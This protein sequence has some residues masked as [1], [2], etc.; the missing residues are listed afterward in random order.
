MTSTIVAR[1]TGKAAK[2]LTAAEELILKQGFKGVTMAAVAQRAHVGKGTAYL[3]WRTKEDLFLELLVDS[4]A[5]V[6]ADL[7][8]RVRATP[9]LAMA[10]RLCPAIAD[11]WLA[12][13]LVRALQV[14]DNDVLGA[15][16]DDPRSHAIVV[17]NGIP[18][19]IGTLLPLWRD[20]DLV[21]ADWSLDDV[22]AALEFLFVG[23]FVTR[24]RGAVGGSHGDHIDVLRR[25]VAAV[26]LTRESAVPDD[27]LTEA[28]CEVLE[29][30]AQRLRELVV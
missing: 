19:L 4:L 8:D 29:N 18:A 22:T 16:L 30:H 11:A 13:P 10:D 28:V 12:R 14:T 26:L 9:G 7:A 25:A 17:E 2:I 20:R 24:T 1:R 21:R 27:D 6:L 5:G 15:L 23:Y 3:Y